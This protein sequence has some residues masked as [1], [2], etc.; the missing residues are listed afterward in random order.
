MRLRISGLV[1]LLVLL[2]VCPARAAI[3]QITAGSAQAS[4]VAIGAHN[5]GDLILLF[6]HRDGSTTAPTLPTGYTSIAS[7]G[8]NTNSNNLG[9][10]VADGTETTTGTCTN[11]TSVAFSI[12]RGW[13][14]IGTNVQN[15]AASATITYS[16]LT[17]QVANGTSWAVGFAGHRTATNVGQA[18]AGMTL[19]SSATDIAVSDTAAGVTG[20]SAASVTVNASSGWRSVVVEVIA[21]QD[22]PAN[23]LASDNFN[24]ANGGLGAN[25][26]TVTGTDAPTITSASLRDPATGGTDAEAFYNAVSFP[27]DQ[28]AQVNT[29][30]AITATSRGVGVLLRND[31]GGARTHYRVMAE[32]PFGTTATVA[33][34]KH[35]SGSFTS[36][37]STTTT[38]NQGDTL[39]GEVQGSTI[40]AKVNGTQVLSTTDTSITSGAA[41]VVVFVDTGTTADAIV[42]D[43]FAGN[44]AAP[45]AGAPSNLPLM[46]CCTAR[47]IPPFLA[48]A[49]CVSSRREG[50]TQ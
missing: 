50:A 8:A 45:P 11:A 43:W 12:Y 39:Y 27:A 3:S 13:T 24:R 34:Q 5:S 22:Q 30:K 14:A 1:A 47:L 17:F 9:F 19:R 23:T 32:G 48:S 2:F 35:V 37:A 38:V 33:I 49:C 25:W 41:G 40:V 28:W 7:G 31:T 15:T 16:A 21:A 4:S 36:L 10:R 18:P 46:G 42:D 20:W 44:F 26:T 29:L 6:C